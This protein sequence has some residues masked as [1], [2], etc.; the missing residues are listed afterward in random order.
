MSSR[1]GQLVHST[2]PISFK[3]WRAVPQKKKDELGKR[4]QQNP[5]CFVTRSQVYLATNRRK[6]GATGNLSRFAKVNV[7]TI[8][9]PTE[10]SFFDEATHSIHDLSG[11]I[12]K[13][14]GVTAPPDRM[15][16]QTKYGA[17]ARGVGAICLCFPHQGYREKIWDHVA[18]YIVV[19]GEVSC[20]SPS[21]CWIF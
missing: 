15:D 16:S 1:C 5:D 8:K 13:K 4:L 17:L 21:Y 6:D 10:A 12:A 14:L 3:D 19:A 11:S 9:N 2:V 7:S 20:F 18:G